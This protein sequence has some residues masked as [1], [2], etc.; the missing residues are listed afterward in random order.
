MDI[1]DVKKWLRGSVGVGYWQMYPKEHSCGVYYHLFALHPIHLPEAANPTETQ[2]NQM[3]G[4][5]FQSFQCKEQCLKS[6]FNL[7]W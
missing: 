4:D 6:N 7:C 5:L 1:L 2:Q 3:G